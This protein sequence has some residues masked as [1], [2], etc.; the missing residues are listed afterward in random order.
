RTGTQGGVAA[1]QLDLLLLR[2]RRRK[3]PRLCR[4]RLSGGRPRLNAVAAAVVAHP[5]DG[6]VVDD[7][8]VVDIGDVGG[9]DIDHRLVVIK[10]AAL[11]IAALKAPADVTIAVAHAAVEADQ[12]TP[13]AAMPVKDPACAAPVPRSP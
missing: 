4:A 11:P 13:V 6:D 12:R 1:R 3:V 10:A 8:P 5:V 7:R 9:A 2:R